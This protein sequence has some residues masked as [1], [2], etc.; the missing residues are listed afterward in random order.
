M[1]AKPQHLHLSRFLYFSRISA[2]STAA[3]KLHFARGMW[4]SLVVS[5]HKGRENK[6]AFSLRETQEKWTYLPLC[7]PQF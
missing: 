4:L 2:E 3:D 5:P 7:C 6:N 1:T